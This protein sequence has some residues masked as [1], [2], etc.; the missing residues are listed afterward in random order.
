MYLF[1]YTHTI[2]ILEE[3]EIDQISSLIR[4]KIKTNRFVVIIVL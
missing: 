1:L 2:L 3:K 4:E